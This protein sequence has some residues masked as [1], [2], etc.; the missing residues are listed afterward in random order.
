[1]TKPTIDNPNRPSNFSLFS[2]F[3]S[4]RLQWPLYMCPPPLCLALPSLGLRRPIP[5]ARVQP[6]V[7]LVPQG[8]AQL[9]RVHLLDGRVLVRFAHPRLL[10]QGVDLG[11]ALLQDEGVLALGLASAWGWDD[12]MPCVVLSIV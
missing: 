1:M 12:G 7:A 3:L 11:N 5:V 4:D 6:L 2:L 8:L 9:L 10:V